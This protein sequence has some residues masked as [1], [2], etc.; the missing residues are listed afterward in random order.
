M[1]VTQHKSSPD[2]VLF[3]LLGTLSVD[4]GVIKSVGAGKHMLMDVQR[5]EML[6][7]SHESLGQWMAKIAERYPIEMK[8]AFQW[9]Y[10]DCIS[11]TPMTIKSWLHRSA[12]ALGVRKDD[13]ESWLEDMQ[14]RSDQRTDKGTW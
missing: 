1:P 13:V 10:S 9:D 8:I 12:G 14:R 5:G 7:G 11:F 4:E 3:R 6:E 2:Y